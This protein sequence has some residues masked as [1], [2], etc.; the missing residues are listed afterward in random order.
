M[1]FVFLALFLA[2]SAVHLCFC[3]SFH[4]IGRKMTKPLL[5]S[6]L[7][8]YYILSA[9]SPSP[10]II[11]ALAASWVGDVLLIRSGES[12][13]IAGGVFFICTHI[14]LMVTF[15][16]EAAFPG[17]RPLITAAAAAAYIALSFAVIRKLRGEASPLM[18]ALLMVY[19]LI[20]ALMNLFALSR[21]TVLGTVG[22]ALVFAGSVCFFLS[23]CALL[24][25]LYLE[26]PPFVYRRNFTVMITYLAAEF[27][28]VSGLLLG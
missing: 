11:A 10:L 6:A 23:D 12:W 22:A 16:G 4:T 3:Y 27:L 2:A 19:L 1:R 13:L 15:A 14:L 24:L 9:E 7:L 28:I 26:D 18:R 20:N 25:L 21:L 17:G 5:I 8:V